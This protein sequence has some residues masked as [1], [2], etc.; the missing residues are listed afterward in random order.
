MTVGF[1]LQT[2]PLPF[3]FHSYS[4]L[5][6]EI[7]ITQAATTSFALDNRTAHVVAVT[8][9]DGTK[10]VKVVIDAPRAVR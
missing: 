3:E 6:H 7:G 2:T 10:T 8:N 1:Q 4:D 5:L 9:K